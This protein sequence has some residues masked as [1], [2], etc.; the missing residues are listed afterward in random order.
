MPVA[1]PAP[2]E[3][4]ASVGDAAAESS[5]TA[6]SSE[7]NAAKKAGRG[8][9]AVALAKVYFILMGLV[10]QVALGRVL[11]LESY[12]ALSTSLQAASIAYN[13]VVQTSIQGVSR[14][15]ASAPE[16][17]RP[18]A[19]RRAL[20]AH[21][22]VAGVG[23]AAF[24]A[25]AEPLGHWMGAPHI[26]L[27]LRLLSAVMVVYGLYAPLV[28]ALNGLHRFLAQAGLDALAATLRTIGLIGG[29]Y[30]FT[31]RAAEL[32]GA[33]SAVG[34][35]EGAILGFVVGATAVLVVSLALVGWGRAGGTEPSLRRHFAFILP[36]LLGQALLNCLF[37]ADA[38]LLRR[39]A[40]E[41][42]QAAGLEVTAADG[43]IGAYRAAQLFCFLPYQ[44]L[45]SVAFVLFPM[46]ARAAATR[47]RDAVRRYV[48]AGIRLGAIVTGLLVSVVSGLSYGLIDLVYGADAARL[49][50]GAARVLAVGLGFLAIFGI[51]TTV[52]N[53]LGR[54]RASALVT[55]L[56]FVLVVVACF[57]GVRGG[58]FGEVLLLRTAWA[59]AAGLT[60]AAL[61]AGWA[62]RHAAG[63]VIS[64]LSALRIAAALA[65]TATLGR[66]LPDGGK[67]MT[68]LY[69]PLLACVYLALLILSRELGREDLGQLR[70][71]VRR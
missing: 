69:A 17:E 9:A 16:A 29:A 26:V 14:V 34:G 4:A 41:A 57:I 20:S 47:D 3:A 59:T 33:S 27:A 39:F 37:Q 19:L 2:S 7:T 44:L 65:L 10:Q 28:G 52:L 40:S 67:W 50:G 35:V 42:A 25:L 43:L 70:A 62:V 51:Q 15:V 71:V 38:L 55:G 53:S 18:A 56:A 30:W 54:E 61:A 32:G 21:A 63:G 60:L 23:G 46:V 48:R 12:G 36:L 5:A 11:G 64:P 22:L 66:F 49:G 68:V 1:S 6:P 45:M 58:P 24:F 13:P 8:G 31:R